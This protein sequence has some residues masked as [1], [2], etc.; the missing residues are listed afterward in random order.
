MSNQK[1]RCIQGAATTYSFW[2]QIVSNEHTIALCEDYKVVA[3]WLNNKGQLGIGGTEE[4]DASGT[5]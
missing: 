2:E 1:K 5:T 3:F 4:A